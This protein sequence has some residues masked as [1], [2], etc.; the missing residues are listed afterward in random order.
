MDGQVP[1]PVKRERMERLVEAGPAARR[2]A[3]P[4]LRRP[5]DGGAGR[6]A[7]PHRRDPPARPHPPQQGGQLR[8][9]RRGRAS[10]SRS[11][12][13][14]RRRRRSSGS[15]SCSPGS[16]ERPGDI[17]ADRGRQ[18]RGGDRSCRPAAGAGG[19]SGG[20]LLRRAA[21]LRGAGEAD[22]R[23][24]APSSRRGSS[25]GWSASCPVTEP[26]SVGDYMRHAHREVDAA[27]AAGRRPIVVGGTGLYLRA[28]I[29]ELSLVKAPPEAEDSELWS[30][31]TRHPT[32]IFGLDMDRELLYER[33]D[34]RTEAIV[35]SGA[36]EEVR[37]AE[38]AG[39]SRTARK[40]LGFDELLGGD[41][42]L[43][44]K[45][46]RNYARRQLTWMRKIP[47]LE[48]VDRAGREDAEIAA[49]IVS[50]THTR[51]RGRLR[52][53]RRDGGDALDRGSARPEGPAAGRQRPPGAVEEPAPD[54]RGVVRAIRTRL[55]LR[56]RA[57][58]GGR[59]RRRRRRSTRSCASARTASGAGARSRRSPKRCGGPP[60]V[61]AAEGDDW[62]RTRRLAV[63]ALNSN[64][65]QRYFEI[66]STCAG[67]LQRQ[68][69]AGGARRAARSRSARPSRRSPS[70]SPRRSPSATT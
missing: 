8:G 65:L 17:R 40:A 14:R 30:P 33:I 34:A 42:E 68:A 2:R 23:G 41:V 44:K 48:W 58:P 32:T 56:H 70:T 21:G 69:R 5:R 52:D 53:W 57:A 29:A 12:S 38:A 37:R 50:R 54:G 36:A 24:D 46:S 19:G 59:D 13:S 15:R 49:E 64:H 7:E 67:R 9:H 63:T 27:L 25:T 55:P 20:D 51:R 47:N 60:G 18:D 43:M 6:G 31:E 26:F 28:A 10:W 1:H 11:R 22:R 35:A 66:V 39:P 16:P 61:F 62:R 3:R 4:A 45:R